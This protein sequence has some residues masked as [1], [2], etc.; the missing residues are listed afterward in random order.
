M[1]LS[2]IV[3]SGHLVCQSPVHV[4]GWEGN[5][6][7][8]DPTTGEPNQNLL[9]VATD[10]AGRYLIPGTSLTGVLR[11]LHELS[12]IQEHMWGSNH[13]G[14]TASRISVHDAIA[15]EF[16]DEKIQP[17]SRTHVSISR[18]SGAASDGMLFDR[19][20]L[21]EGTRLTFRLAVE[22]DEAETRL[23]ADSTSCDECGCSACRIARELINGVEV[24]GGTGSG[25][26]SVQLE[27]E[28]PQTYPMVEVIQWD[29]DGMLAVLQGTRRTQEFAAVS[30]GHERTSVEVTWRALGP[31]MSKSPAADLQDVAVPEHV[32][33]G[34][35][36]HLL[37]PGSSIRGVFRSQAERIMATAFGGPTA[38]RGSV[39]AEGQ[40]AF[41]DAS[42]CAP[43]S[44]GMRIGPV[45]LLFGA[46]AGVSN[47]PH[48][49]SA[50]GLRGVL[51]FRDVQSKRTVPLKKWEGLLAEA[52]K[53]GDKRK[54]GPQDQDLGMR[55]TSR[56]A[57]ERWTGG[58][59]EGR[60]YATLEPYWLEPGDWD[61]IVFS[62]DSHRLRLSSQKHGEDVVKA[63]LGLLWLVVDDLRRQRFSIGFGQSRG[64]GDVDVTGIAGHGVSPL[65][66]ASAS[67][68]PQDRPQDWID[69]LVSLEEQAAADTSLSTGGV[70]S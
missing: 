32:I 27:G 53:A 24:G 14:G 65:D 58:V 22:A 43:F 64:Y 35:N 69:S 55:F 10:A 45:G 54:K 36:V 5:H 21:K 25:L 48:G 51:R 63:A 16:P 2:R 34:D 23:H 46:A 19:Q 41:L 20:F 66:G 17:G 49:R 15:V 7:F 40:L 11:A 9:P 42:T 62:L 68:W 31:V 1:A 57:I 52:R 60:L 44:T 59:A 47:D 13:E 3:V 67:W 70:Q 18:Y 26:G 61:P 12:D 50:T 8:V 56:V 28:G 6:A 33:K 30:S 37:L 4:G 29:R 39:D 38:G